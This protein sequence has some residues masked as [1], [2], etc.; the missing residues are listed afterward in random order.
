MIIVAA[1]H[2]ILTGQTTASWPDRFDAWAADREPRFHVLKKEYV[3]GP[4]P[5]LNWLK[6]R[7]L[8]EGL[9]R[10]IV[11]FSPWHGDKQV[12]LV[13]HSN[14]CVIALQTARLLIDTNIRIDGM[15]LTGGACPSDV[16]RN[17]VAE[18][19]GAGQLGQAVAFSSPSDRVVNVRGFWKFLKWPYGDLGRVGWR[20]DGKPFAS[21]SISTRWFSGGHSGYFA[22]D[23]M[24]DTF[25]N[26]AAI[27]NGRVK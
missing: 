16:D 27:I 1:I 9:A 21:G 13:G 12:W 19:I 11:A 5:R 22:A 15:I 3:A 6:N 14:G 4:F 17:H 18:W 25:R 26:F 8:A 10:E 23:R 7:R 24:E 20:R 2:G